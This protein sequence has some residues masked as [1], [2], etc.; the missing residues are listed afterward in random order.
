MRGKGRAGRCSL[1]HRANSCRYCNGVGHDI[2]SA[3]LAGRAVGD[4]R[5]TLRD[6]MD[7]RG[8]DG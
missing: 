1:R 5:W 8:V 3:R 4:A 6:G 2:S 7:R